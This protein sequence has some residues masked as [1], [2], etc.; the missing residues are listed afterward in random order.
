VQIDSGA[1]MTGCG[2]INGD[3]QIDGT[4]ASSCGGTIAVSGDVTVN[5]TMRLTNSTAITV[6]GT[7]TNN[8]VLDIL[9]GSQT[10]PANFVNNGVVLDSREVEDQALTLSGS[11]VVVTVV[12]Y[13][14]HNYQLQRSDSLNPENWTN[15]GAAQAGGGNTLTFTDVGGV[16]GT[17]RYYRV[18]LSP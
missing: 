7:F 11:N 15:I 8:G 18:I 1:T 2:T 17:Q 9:T 16:S 5:G 14:G 4:L 6:G 13:T 3:L 12:G 10:L